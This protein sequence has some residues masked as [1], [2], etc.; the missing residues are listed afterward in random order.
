MSDATQYRRLYILPALSLS[1]LIMMLTAC[2]GINLFEEYNTSSAE[3]SLQDFSPENVQAVNQLSYAAHAYVKHF[4]RWPM[5]ENELIL[6]SQNQHIPYPTGKFSSITFWVDKD[7]QLHIYVIVARLA[8]YTMAR[9]F[10]KLELI[11]S[12]SGQTW[13]KVIGRFSDHPGEAIEIPQGENEVPLPF[14]ESFIWPQSDYRQIYCQ[15]VTRFF[16]A[17]RC[18]RPV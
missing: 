14:Y 4:H 12:S 13:I 16:Y 18:Q 5:N 9:Y 1:L 11:L 7:L 8:D 6:F 10:A 15:P 2:S 17:L 3:M